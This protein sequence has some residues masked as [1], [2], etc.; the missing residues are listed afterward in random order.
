MKK[1]VTY[2]LIAFALWWAIQNP[3]AAAH[4]VHNV[5]GFINHAINSVSTVANSHR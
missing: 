3:V 2:A 4:L 1:F 5:A